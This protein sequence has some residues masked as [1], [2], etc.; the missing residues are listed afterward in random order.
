MNGE[1]GQALPLAIL[2]LAIGTLVITPFLGHASSNL[3]G[4]Q[5][6]EQSLTELYACDAGIEYAIWSLLSGNLEVEEGAIESLPQ[7]SLNSKTVDVTVENLGSN[8]YLVTSTATSDD[9]HSSTIESYVSHGGGGW[10][11]DGDIEEDT[12]G[13]AY[14]D[15]DADIGSNATVDGSV[16][17][18][19]NVTLG[20]NA[21]VTGDV[22]SEGDLDLSNNAVIGGDVSAS[23]DLTLNNNSEIGS[24]EVEGNVCAGGDTNLYNNAVIYGN[25]Y[26]TG[27]VHLNGNAIIKGNLFVG[28]DIATIIMDNNARI[29]GSI[30]ISG[31][32]TT[33]IQLANNARIY[34]DVYATGTI[35]NI[36]REA[37][38]LGDVYENYTG[39]YP[40]SPDCPEMADPGGGTGIVSW[41]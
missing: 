10:T 27:N 2:A 25:V 6:Y 20:N 4:S 5:V 3:I 16:Y 14:I 33:K 32:V 23:G 35:S 12:E 9:S 8:I 30:Y 41:D 36:I 15:G 26:T 37:N 31:S 21:E 19:G 1:K 13:D 18:T 22:V 29:E 28:A 24:I 17:A 40:P 38:I 7:F 34:E 39:S 11:S